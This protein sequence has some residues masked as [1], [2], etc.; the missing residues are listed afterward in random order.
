[1]R[2]SALAATPSRRRTTSSGSGRRS[3]R[4]RRRRR[5]P[6]PAGT[7]RRTARPAL[8]RT[9][10]RRWPRPGAALR[11]MASMRSALTIE[12]SSITSVS[13]VLSILRSRSVWSMS[14]SAMTP[15]GSRNSEWIVCPPTLSAATPVGAQIAICF[16][17]VP[18]RWLSSVDLPVPARPVTKT[19]SR[20]SSIAVE[21]GSLF[22]RQ[23]KRHDAPFWQ[24]LVG[25]CSFQL[26]PLAPRFRR[27]AHGV[28]AQT[29][30]R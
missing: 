15:I 11:S 8:R 9:A 2:R 29:L 18:V 28:V 19:W 7:G 22:R 17:G 23:R 13:I 20:V 27:V 5:A 1:M 14:W 12:T 16:V 26:Y 3:R 6:G 24:G 21:D 30:L 25:G 10:R 4:A